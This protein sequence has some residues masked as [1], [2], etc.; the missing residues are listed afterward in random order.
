MLLE[1]APVVENIRLSR[2][3]LSEV[4]GRQPAVELGSPNQMTLQPLARFPTPDPDPDPDVLPGPEPD[5]VHL[6]PSDPEP[7]FPSDPFPTPAPV[8]Q[9]INCY[10]QMN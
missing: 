3:R 5:P 4:A 7:G 1:V 9:E 10:N 6:P 2:N 8:F